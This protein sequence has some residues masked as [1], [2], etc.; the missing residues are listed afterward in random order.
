MTLAK[1]EPKTPFRQA[2]AA[3]WNAVGPWYEQ[4]LLVNYSALACLHLF[5][6]AWTSIE[7]QFGLLPGGLDPWAGN[8]LS[9]AMA[10]L[11]TTP[12][13]HLLFAAF[14]LFF[15]DY[16]ILTAEGWGLW[17]RQGLHLLGLTL[18]AV[19]VASFYLRAYCQ[20]RLNG[21]T[22]L[23]FFGLLTIGAVAVALAAGNNIVLYG[24]PLAEG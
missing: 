16:P 22:K 10:A 9:G 7:A 14:S 5:L 21:R 3:R 18:T 4:L 2:L 17:L 20:G 12:L 15:L 1:T 19:L 13:H 11:D 6:L 8:T 24:H 23:F